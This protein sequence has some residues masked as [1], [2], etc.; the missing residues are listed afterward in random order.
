MEHY[1]VGCR[2]CFLNLLQVSRNSLE[3]VRQGKMFRFR[4]ILWLPDVGFS[5]ESFLV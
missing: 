1:V 2:S 3:M 4:G 5:F